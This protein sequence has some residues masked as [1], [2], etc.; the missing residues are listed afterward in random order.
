[1]DPHSA[2]VHMARLL[3]S[4]ETYRKQAMD[5][6]HQIDEGVS[7]TEEDSEELRFLN[8]DIDRFEERCAADPLLRDHLDG[9]WMIDIHGPAAVGQHKLD[10]LSARL[11][12]ADSS[13]L[14]VATFMDTL[15]TLSRRVR[16][17]IE[18]EGIYLTD[19]GAGSDGWDLGA[20]CNDAQALRLCNE[21]HERFAIEI[22][23]G[24]LVVS[25]RFW[26]WR[27]TDMPA[28]S[29]LKA[30]VAEASTN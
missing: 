17:C 11:R 20:M 23:A 19:A 6:A 21:L 30:Y 26:G 12:E 14:D 10:E 8:G 24:A 29:K 27:F 28:L 22:A 4:A 5:R 25:K 1:M 16:A 3:L 9:C 18:L 2:K 15:G 7:I 13:E